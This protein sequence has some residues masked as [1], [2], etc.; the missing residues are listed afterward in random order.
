[1]AIL[2]SVEKRVGVALLYYYIFF[3]PPAG[4]CI[5]AGTMR[6]SG[7][8]RGGGRYTRIEMVFYK[9]VPAQLTIYYVIKVIY[10]YYIIVCRYRVRHV[11]NSYYIPG[12]MCLDIIKYIELGGHGLQLYYIGRGRTCL[13]RYVAVVK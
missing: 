13:Y 5:R 6:P 2:Y 3:L 10:I 7:S 4:L 8:R 11:S 12:I 1:M 9:Y